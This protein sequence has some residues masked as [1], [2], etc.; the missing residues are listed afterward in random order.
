MSRP[1]ASLN[2]ASPQTLGNL[3][4]YMHQID[5]LRLFAVTVV[6]FHHFMEGV[7]FPLF[8]KGVILFFFLS[9]YFS[10]RQLLQIKERIGENNGSIRRGVT[11]FYLRRYIRI[12]PMYYGILICAVLAGI[13]H[14]RESFVWLA[15]F[16]CNWQILFQEEWIGPFSPFWSL[17]LLEQF[18]LLWPTLFLAIPKKWELRITLCLIAI[19]VLWRAWCFQTEQS[20][21]MWFVTPWAGYDQIGLGALVAILHAR[22]K[23]NPM[24]I[25]RLRKIGLYIAGPASAFLLYGKDLGNLASWHYIYEPTLNCCFFIWLVDSTARG[26]QGSIGRA[27]SL[28]LICALG[29]A[30]YSIFALHEFSVYLLPA[31]IRAPLA[32]VLESPWQ[33]IILIPETLLIAWLSYRFIETPINRLKRFAKIYAC[34]PNWLSYRA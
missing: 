7:Y 32:P 33:W 13:P 18:Y 10:T 25:L 9:G 1:T 23:S 3:A 21:F 12:F 15:T 17:A 30:S 26:H 11:V 6:M 34:F 24:L 8:G 20:S 27:L 22:Q 19:A 14:A 5:A 2:P 29:R 28:P 16:T 4:P 31:I